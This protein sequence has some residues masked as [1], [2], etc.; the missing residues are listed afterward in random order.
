MNDVPRQP[1][2]QKKAIVKSVLMAF[3]S[4]AL[5]AYFVL[6]YDFAAVY[7]QLINVKPT[8]I[9]LILA[10]TFSAHFIAAIKWKILAPVYSMP[11]LFTATMIGHFYSAVLPGQLFGE[12]SKIFHLRTEDRIDDGEKDDGFIAASVVVD[13][14]MGLVALVFLAMI[15]SACSG[16]SFAGSLF[17]VFFI[18]FVF[19]V[20][21]LLS[22]RIPKIQALLRHLVVWGG[23]KFPKLYK[24]SSKLL[25]FIDAWERYI[26]SP[27]CL[28]YSFLLNALYQFMIFLINALCG[29]A[30]GI[31][32]TIWNWAWIASFISFVVLLPIS[33]GGLG[34]RE[35]S[36]ISL[37]RV[38]GVAA[39][40]SFS[41]S[42]VL[43]AAQLIAAVF[44]GM[45]LLYRA[46]RRKGATA[47]E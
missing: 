1:Q 41:F 43:L 9:F 13:K 14:I 29:M 4:I 24:L 44:G 39:E 38:L 12:A 34:I 37:L 45:L 22:L 17:V 23:Q 46:T 27:R 15:G 42:I 25:R 7:Q 28:L 5:V 26:H 8:Y 11:Q 6:Q 47:K 18:S 16:Q 3:V 32:I 10:A 30:V 40:A 20:A 2:N 21:V 33:I 35:G 36:Y 19:L 31:H